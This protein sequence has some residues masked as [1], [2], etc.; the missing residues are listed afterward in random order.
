MSPPD[1]D[2][3]QA[4][5]HPDGLADFTA[6][7]QRLT[8]SAR[9]RV[10]I[11][12]QRVDLRYLADAAVVTALRQLALHNRRARI[13]ILLPPGLARDGD[14]LALWNLAARLPSFFTVHCLGDEHAGFGEALLT[15]DKLSYLHR[16]QPDRL[17]GDACEDDP[18]RTKDLNLRFE[19]L[20]L[21]SA[22]D[23]DSRRLGL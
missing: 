23:P 3:P 15:V 9:E 1:A 18:A 5:L 4:L 22:P 11:L 21:A 10:R 8:E 13:E 20:W 16:S 17:Q 14:G 19:E 6:L 2:D 12:P 7:A